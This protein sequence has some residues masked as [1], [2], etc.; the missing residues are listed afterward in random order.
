MITDSPKVASR[1]ESAAVEGAVEQRVLEDEPERRHRAGRRARAGRAGSTSRCRTSVT[2]R[3]AASTIE[4]AVREV[5]EP[6]DAEHERQAGGE[7]RVQP[8]EEHAL[9]D[10]VRP[11]SIVRRLR[12]TPRRSASRVSSAG[13]PVERDAAL[14]QAVDAVGDRERLADVLLDEQDRRA[15]AARWPAIAVVELPDD[16]RREPERDLVEQEQARVRH[17]APVRSRSACCSPP[18][19]RAAASSREELEQ[20][21]Q[22]VDLAHASHGPPGARCAPTRRFSS[23]VRLGKMRRPSGHEGDPGRDATVGSQPADRLAVEA[24]LARRAAAAGPP[25]AASS[26]DLPAP[27]APMIA[28]VSPSS[29]SSET[30]KSAWKSP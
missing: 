11:R 4:V 14:E 21:E 30:S 23:T 5:D 25:T 22:V 15:L 8:A 10:R 19:R 9:D 7:Q 29:T 3:N 28:T 6:H 18:E 2:A 16:D 20:R 12:S 27:L 26:V 24:D 13:R 17:A 1:G